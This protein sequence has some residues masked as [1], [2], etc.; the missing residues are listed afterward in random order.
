MTLKEVRDE[1]ADAAIEKALVD[2]GGNLTRAAALLGVSV[3]TLRRRRRRMIQ[4]GHSCPIEDH[5]SVSDN[6]V[7]AGD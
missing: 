7:H 1:A 2:T 3:R 5:G 4:G 6:A